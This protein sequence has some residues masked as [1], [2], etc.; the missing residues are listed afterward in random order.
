MPHD[1]R[2]KWASDESASNL[3]EGILDATED[4]AREEQSALQRAMQQRE[5][6]AREA[7]QKQE[8]QQREEASARMAREERRQEEVQQR[9]TAALRAITIADAPVE[10]PV[11]TSAQPLPHASPLSEEEFQTR[12]SALRAEQAALY[13]ATQ[14]PRQ[15]APQ[16]PP[17]PSPWMAPLLAAAVVVLVGVG[18]L[19]SALL[20][21]SYTP[22]PTPYTKMVL[23]PV[24]TR[25]VV[26]GEA[27]SPLPQAE[28]EL[29]APAAA[30]DAR[31]QKPKQ[32]RPH[33]SKPADTVT[34][35][36]TVTKPK[37]KLGD[38]LGNDDDDIFGTMDKSGQ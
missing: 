3:L 11:E 25:D 14:Q 28:P 29:A 37:P 20:F 4:A 22:D 5:D 19:V 8:L 35:T 26:T 30:P 6:A 1:K 17:A 27:F 18:A 38:L 36:T 2:N 31:G 21:P 34:A 10:A 32:N 9:R 24:T 23:H 16:A 12:M 13:E 33:T 7:R 15:P